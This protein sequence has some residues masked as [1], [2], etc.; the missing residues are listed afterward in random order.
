MEEGIPPLPYFECSP[1]LPHDPLMEIFRRLDC[2]EL[3]NASAVSVGWRSAAVNSELWRELGRRRFGD[4]LA[5]PSIEKGPTRVAGLDG[6]YHTLDWRLR[7]VQ[8]QFEQLMSP[9]QLAERRTFF[10]DEDGQTAPAD[11]G[12][13]WMRRFHAFAA[14]LGD[15]PW[16]GA[17]V[18]A[19]QLKCAAA[20]ASSVA[21]GRQHVCSSPLQELADHARHVIP[22]R[23]WAACARCAR[24]V[25]DDCV[26]GVHGIPGRAMTRCDG[27]LRLFCGACDYHGLVRFCCTC[28]NVRTRSSWIIAPY[29]LDSCA[30]MCRLLLPAVI[31]HVLRGRST[32]RAVR[33]LHML[34]VCR[35]RDT[36]VL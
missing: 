16:G 29:F 27:C 12:L 23:R 20:E 9:S 34:T 31:L 35:H 13:W 14:A 7:L 28:E 4:Q 33:C 32:V 15:D 18:H 10:L 3:L 19:V 5:A 25:C 26:N 24:V 22:H 6:T 8:R 1:P 30:E 17:A 21:H 2:S 11:H 36:D